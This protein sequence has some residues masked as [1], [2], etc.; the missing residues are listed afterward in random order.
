MIPKITCL[1][2]PNAEMLKFH[3]ASSVTTTL[4]QRHVAFHDFGG[5]NAKCPDSLS[6]ELSE[7]SNPEMQKIP[8][9]R[10]ING[11]CCFSSNRP[12]LLLSFQV[13]EKVLALTHFLI[14][15]IR[16]FL[17]SSTLLHEV[18]PPFNFTLDDSFHDSGV[19]VTKGFGLRSKLTNPESPK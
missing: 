8:L 2:P 5:F 1:E 14:C 9:Q 17:R 16:W 4:L 7:M 12:L 10:G 3:F 6:S 13:I 11:S 18:F 19:R 15:K